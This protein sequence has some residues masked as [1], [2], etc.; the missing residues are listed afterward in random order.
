MKLPSDIVNGGWGISYEIA[1]K[2]MPLDLTDEKSTLV[3]AMA[4]CRQAN[5]DPD[6]CR[7]MASLGLNELS[8]IFNLIV[9]KSNSGTNCEN[10]LRW[11]P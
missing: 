4:W 3:Q 1:L 2:W 5:V 7:Q 8:I 6:L 10:A 9:H 11:M